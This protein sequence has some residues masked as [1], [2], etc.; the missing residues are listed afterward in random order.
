LSIW[1][2]RTLEWIAVAGAGA[3][4]LNA[5]GEPSPS[6]ISRTSVVDSALASVGTRGELRFTQAASLV[7]TA[8]LLALTPRPGV[9]VDRE[10]TTLSLPL[11]VVSAGVAVGF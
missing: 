8:R 6:L 10:R 9:A 7:A 1:R 2:N 11:V 5:R 3:Y 4:H